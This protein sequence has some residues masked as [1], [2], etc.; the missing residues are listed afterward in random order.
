MALLLAA[1]STTVITAASVSLLMAIPAAAL[2]ETAGESNAAGRA[3]VWLAALCVPPLLGVLV[4]G[5]ALG[6]YAQGP[7]ASPHLGGFRP[8]LCLVPLVTAPGGAVAVQAFAW[9]S[10][11]L[12]VAAVARMLG[13]TFSA[14]L[15]RRM[16][17][18]S[19]VALDGDGQTPLLV[20]IGRPVCFTAGLLRPVTVLSTSLRARL[21]C[22]EL[23]AVL[24]H[25]RAHLRRRDNLARLLADAATT[26]LVIMPTVW[27]YRR[28]LRSA[29]E[30]AAD[31][32]AVAMG[33]QPEELAGA[34]AAMEAAADRG[35]RQPSLAELLIPEPALPAARRRR[36]EA[37]EEQPLS[38]AGRRGRTAMLL[39]AVVGVAV[40]AVLLIV[41]RRPLEDGLYCAVE[42]IVV[43][44]T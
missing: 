33:T 17:L 1:A 35:P 11:L 30:E 9:L 23:R 29:L 26:L 28:R 3:R 32:A 10:L 14:H 44:V 41:A 21:S 36:L 8:H 16:M 34:L 43:A 7:G 42:Q 15:L 18:A 12:T 19:G 13:T 37:I 40:V 27:Y 4:T 22:R 2:A 24:A 38:P 6:L 31:D 20:E 25:E 39:A 5:W